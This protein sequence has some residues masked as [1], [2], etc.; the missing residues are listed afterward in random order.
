MLIVPA[1]WV[2]S[3]FFR[4]HLW[5]VMG[6]GTFTS[7]AIYSRW[8]K[9]AEFASPGWALG[10]CIAA[11][12]VSYVGAIIW[13]YEARWLGKG[14]ILA[15][16]ALFC[17]AKY[18][19]T[20]Q[21]TEG[22]ASAPLGVLLDFPTAAWLMGLFLA[23]MLL[24][25]WYLNWPGMKLAPLKLLVGLSALAVLVRALVSGADLGILA[26]AGETPTSVVNW[27]FIVFRWLAGLVF[28]AGMAWLTW[29]T[30]KIPNTQSAT[31]IMYAAVTLIF[32][33]ELTSQLLSRSLPVPV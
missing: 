12:V 33:G 19:S 28:P 27:S 9:Y 30:L 24:G 29:E 1:R 5:V 4:V 14:F 15:A 10:F 16:A 18:A 21:R 20:P 8:E 6:L 7:L 26:M 2:T 25:H 22:W 17:A 31:G 3:G 13:M 11:A 23:A 32:L